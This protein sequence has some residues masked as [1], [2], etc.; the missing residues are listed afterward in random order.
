MEHIALFAASSVKSDSIV[1]IGSNRQLPGEYFE[2]LKGCYKVLNG[3][4]DDYSDWY[5]D[6]SEDLETVRYFIEKD[7]KVVSMVFVGIA[8]IGNY[9]IYI[10][11]VATDKDYQRKGYAKKLLK[12]IKADYPGHSIGLDVKTTNSAALKLYQSVGFKADFTYMI[13]EN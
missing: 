1:V 13:L 9:Y 8:S 5:K 4:M 3:S 6:N 10:V 2:K 12:R 11:N 7:G